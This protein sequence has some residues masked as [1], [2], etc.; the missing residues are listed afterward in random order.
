MT[1]YRIKLKE[2]WFDFDNYNSA[3]LRAI[4]LLHQ[5]CWWFQLETEKDKKEKKNAERN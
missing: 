3:K 2:Q 5:G 1:V 4:E